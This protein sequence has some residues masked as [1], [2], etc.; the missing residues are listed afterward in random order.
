[1]VLVEALAAG[2]PVVGARGR[3]AAG[4]PRRE[5]RL[6]P[7]G[8]A[9]AAAAQIRDALADPDARAEARRRAPRQH[10]DVRD[11]TRGSAA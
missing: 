8:D 10:F 11:S 2:R 9:D 4:D 7:P 5:G 3:R 6:Y 1:M